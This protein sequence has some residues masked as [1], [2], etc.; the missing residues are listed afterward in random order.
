MYRYKVL[1]GSGTSCC[2]CLVQG[3]TGF[4]TRCQSLVQGVIR[5]G[6]MCDK[7]WYNERQSLVKGVTKSGIR[8]DRVWY[9]V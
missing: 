3:V 4:G 8:C 6:I 9:K 5:P 7:V 2:E 1:G